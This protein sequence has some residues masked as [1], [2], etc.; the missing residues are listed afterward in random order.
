MRREAMEKEMVTSNISKE[1]ELKEWYNSLAHQNDK[2]AAAAFFDRTREDRTEKIKSFSKQ[3][4]E[5]EN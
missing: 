3:W 1:K 2:E 5:D 4:Q